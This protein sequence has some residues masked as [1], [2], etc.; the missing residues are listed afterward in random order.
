MTSSLPLA[1][2][3]YDWFFILAFSLFTITSIVTDTVNGWGGQLDPNSGYAVERYIYHS[4]AK[5]CDPLLI[6]NPPQVK[7]SAWISATIWL[8][9]YVWF[10]IG[11]IR[12]NARI[13]VPGLVYGGAL[14]HGMITY[15]AEGMFG[16]YARE[17]WQTLPEVV[18]P[19]TAYYFW[20]NLPY[21]LV[22]ALMIIRMWRP[23]PFGSQAA[24]HA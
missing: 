12:G 18:A 11:F 8:P 20:V 4:Y 10:V 21:L 19:D 2:R 3:W 13:R 17:G 9:M 1:K 5:F 6:Y 7:V 15:M 22:P 24:A 23:D 14:A 16:Y